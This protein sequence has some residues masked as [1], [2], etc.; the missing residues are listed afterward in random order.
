MTSLVALMK[1]FEALIVS[2]S[3][4]FP[5]SLTIYNSYNISHH[6]DFAHISQFHFDND[7]DNDGW[8]EEFSI[9][10]SHL[11]VSKLYFSGK[12]NNR[13]VQSRAEREMTKI[14]F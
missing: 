8:M 10:E 6:L 3:N 1:H 14:A 5:L 4:R 11:L 12:A 9:F 2:H 13:A 7:Y